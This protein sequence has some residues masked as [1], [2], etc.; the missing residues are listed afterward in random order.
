MAKISMK[1]K[2][3]V[4]LGEA[5]EL[6]FQKCKIKNLSEK[7][8][9]SYS[10][11]FHWLFEF[12]GEDKMVADITRDDIDDY[13][14]F[15]REEKEITE[16][17][18]NSYLRSARALFYYCMECGYM[19]HFKIHTIK[20]DQRVKETYSD[21]ELERLLKKPD[22]N[23]ASFTEYKTWV[24]ENYLLGT[25]NRL[26]TALNIQI[27]DIDF[28]NGYIRLRKT[29][30]RKEQLFPLSKALSEVLQEYLMIRRGDPDEYL[31][32]SDLQNDYDKFSPLDSLVGSP[33]RK[34]KLHR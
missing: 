15:L 24:F 8:I 2:E 20:Q 1:P 23:T 14:L 7:T 16:T 28:D 6:F 21:D 4:T 10:N 17:S 29:K 18:C 32:G 9:E 27:G 30:N 13:I 33:D 3:K 12:F 26:S 34:K 22:R 31:F 19:S 25:G 11:H 5:R